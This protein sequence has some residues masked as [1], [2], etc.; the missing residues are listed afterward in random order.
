MVPM[1]K[2]GLR[3]P[4]VRDQGKT[5]GNPDARIVMSRSNVPAT[6][7]RSGA[8]SNPIVFDGTHHQAYSAAW[9]LAHL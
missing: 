2:R 7:S 6:W 1:R 3:I 8:P 4:C 9:T 5:T